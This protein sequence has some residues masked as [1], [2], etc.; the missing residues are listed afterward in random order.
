MEQ[1]WTKKV[2]KYDILKQLIKYKKLWYNHVTYLWWEPFIQAVFLDALLLW[3]KL[4]YTILV[5]TNC[6][7]L[8]IDSQAKK[9]LPYIDELF[10]S[11]EALSIEEQQKISR[12]KNYVHWEKVFENIK[13]YWKW[14]TLKANMVITQ[15][16]KNNLFELVEYVSTKWIKEIAIT[17]PDINYNYY[18]K[19]F[20]L[21]KIAPRYNECIWDL[22]KIVDFC[23]K[24]QIR[25]KIPD[26]PFCVFPE[27]KREEMIKLTDDFDFDTRIKISHTDEKI[28]R[29]DLT[30]Y[31]NLPRRRQKVDKC[32]ICKYNKTCWWPS[33]VYNKL[34]WLDEINPTN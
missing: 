26:F 29:W 30:D 2:S 31:K 34:Y 9:F 13:K 28:D 24:N 7:T 17:Y 5:T 21:E 25:L 10:L 1:A 12:T 33:H 15:D 4:G 19:D 18:W 22:V 14:K 32:N 23:T 3:K 20:I 8:H 11:V 27:N 16:N 6:T